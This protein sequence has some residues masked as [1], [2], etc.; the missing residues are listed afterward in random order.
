MPYALLNSKQS[1]PV[2]SPGVPRSVASSNVNSLACDLWDGLL[3]DPPLIDAPG[4]DL[5]VG[6]AAG[7]GRIC[8]LT[9]VKAGG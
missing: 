1:I 9:S 5:Y 8:E 2:L 4:D 3:A 6:L 7:D